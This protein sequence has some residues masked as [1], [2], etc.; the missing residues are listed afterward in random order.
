MTNFTVKLG[1]SGVK[2]PY[3]DLNYVKSAADQVKFMIDQVKQAADYV[4]FAV[5]LTN[6]ALQNPSGC[7][8]RAVIMF[9]SV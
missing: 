1:W 4:K 5:K 6:S 3:S 7:D 2:S 9:R 8:R